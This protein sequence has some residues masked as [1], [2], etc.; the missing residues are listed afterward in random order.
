[1]ERDRRQK[2]VDFVVSLCA[3]RAEVMRPL[4]VPWAARKLGEAG[5]GQPQREFWALSSLAWSALGLLTVPVHGRF[6]VPCG[7]PW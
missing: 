7:H 4:P 6:S 2:L 5:Q 1:M 3:R